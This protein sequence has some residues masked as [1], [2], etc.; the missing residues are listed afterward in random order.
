MALTADPPASLIFYEPPLVVDGSSQLA[1]LAAAGS[2]RVAKGAV[3]EIDDVINSILP[4]RKWTQFDGTS[5]IQFVSKV[6]PS[7]PELAQLEAAL[8]QR[9]NQRQARNKGLCPVRSEL[10]G[11]LF[12]ELVRQITLDLPERGL[13]LLRIRDEIRMTLDAYRTLYESSIAFGVRKQLQAEE[14]LPELEGALTELLEKKKILESQVLAIKSKLEL[15]QRRLLEKRTLEEKRWA[16]EIAF[17]FFSVSSTQ[18][19]SVLFPP[20][21]E[22]LTFIHTKHSP[23][24]PF[25]L[26]TAA[27]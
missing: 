1:A 16:E 27:T 14:G 3:S 19:E 7:R 21:C 10:H 2:K 23:P 24:F 13:L 20:P 9:L 17:V 4:P 6:P 22:T 5:W 18:N 8:E 26:N 12:D 11:Q 25:L 15:N